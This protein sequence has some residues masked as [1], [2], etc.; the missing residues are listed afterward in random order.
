MWD[1]AS[2]Q[3]IANLELFVQSFTVNIIVRDICTSIPVEQ[4]AFNFRGTGLHPL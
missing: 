4:S 1:S 2:R 3:Y